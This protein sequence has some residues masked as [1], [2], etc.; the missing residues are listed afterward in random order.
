MRKKMLNKFN[1]INSGGKIALMQIM[2]LIIGMV[3]VVYMVGVV[4][5]YNPG[6][7]IKFGE[8]VYI[9]GEQ[10]LW[11]SDANQNAFDDREMNAL[12][13]GDLPK[14]FGISTTPL[15][16][17]GLKN[18]VAIPSTE[19]GIIK[20]TKTIDFEGNRIS[21]VKEID[22]KYFFNNKDGVQTEIPAGKLQ[23]TL[24]KQ[25]SSWL[26]QKLNLQTGGWQDS[27]L[28][29]A[30]WAGIAFGVA[31]MVGG[32]FLDDKD[33]INALSFAAAGGLFVGRTLSIGLADKGFITGD[34]SKYFTFG[35]KLSP[36]A[37]SFAW[38]AITF[39][40]I[41][42]AM[43]NDEEKEIIT[44]DCVPW[45][46]PVGGRDCEKCNDQAEELS[47]SEYQCRSLGQACQLLN[48]G[49][50]EEKCE[51]INKNDVKFPI[52][53]P[54]EEALLP[55]YIYTPD[56]TISPPD[57]GV[58]IINRNSE[59]GC[60]H[61]FTPLSF[62]VLLNE[63]GKCK[64]DYLRRSTFD[65]MNF[66]LGG[67]SLFRYN[68]TEIMNLPGGDNLASEELIIQNNG[69]Y[70]LYV[71][72]MDAN[73]NYNTAN[74]V[75]K[76]CVDQGPDTTPP[77]IVTTSALN[78]AP[79]SYG[80]TDLNLEVYINEPANCKWSHLDKN[81]EDMEETMICSQSVFEMNAQMVYKCTTTLTGL[82]NSQDNLFY[83]RCED[84]PLASVEDR[85]RNSQS[86][87]FKLIGTQPILID[88]AG[89]NGTVKDASQS[90][91]VTLEA[92][93]SAGYKEG[94]ATCYYSDTGEDNDYIMFY[95]TNSYEHSQEL[96]LGEG[97]YEYFIKCNDLGGNSDSRRLNFNVE[98]DSEAPAVMRAYH[99]E[100]YLK[101][102]TSEEAE[103]VYDTVDCS[104]LFEDGNSISVVDGINHFLD[105][106]TKS[107][108]YVKCIDE[109]GNQP[110]P[111][112]CNIIVRPI[113]IFED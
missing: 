96:Y 3:A 56:N 68:H 18:A 88:F 10:D 98:S 76:Y 91:R 49:T 103:C 113:E 94:E 19:D 9:R 44:Y 2:I 71:R 13:Q 111:N 87:V 41:M 66:W 62:G 12:S 17:A 93:T 89:P 32:F 110:A 112:T 86:Y 105:W 100:N 84:K 97:D 53:I 26:S 65:E 8:D 90:V 73:G 21:E 51:W 16:V 40:V 80:Q 101:L 55:D 27:I 67:N 54:W 20:L 102:I 75:F 47:C 43:W 4:S 83:F 52:I 59:N 34:W 60:T 61:A 24:P 78:G 70:D 79:V 39:A 85:N 109:F 82:K 95:D 22:N 46:A 29:G 77:F 48:P 28:S 37:A 33:Q 58:I 92:K 107:T 1:K 36:G 57:R 104:Y 38:G 72:C 7:Q 11:T 42:F 50:N 35:N 99:E 74:F 25:G 108:I 15:S 30:Q 31:Q 69:N 5:G 81:F 64:I 106:D 45:D 23:G 6:D 63:P 14:D